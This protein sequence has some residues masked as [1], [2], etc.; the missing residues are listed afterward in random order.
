MV[1][2]SFFSVMVFSVV[3]S[4]VVVSQGQV[5]LQRSPKMLSMAP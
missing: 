1:L 3:F 5:V 4:V 2:V